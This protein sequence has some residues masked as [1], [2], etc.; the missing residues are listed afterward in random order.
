MWTEKHRARAATRVKQLKRYPSDLT[1]EEW[2]LMEPLMPDA[3]N[4]GRRRTV[5]FR[6]AVNAIRYLVCFGCE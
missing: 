1:D 2:A 4:V 6:E 3:A 5:D